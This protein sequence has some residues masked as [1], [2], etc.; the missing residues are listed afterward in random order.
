LKKDGQFIVFVSVCIA[1]FLELNKTRPSCGLAGRGPEL[2][3][4]KF[5][6]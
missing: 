1:D 5:A 6:V 4:D 2:T 3:R